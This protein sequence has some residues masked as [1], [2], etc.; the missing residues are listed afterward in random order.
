MDAVS[1]ALRCSVSPR[2]NRL[3]LALIVPEFPPDTIGGGGPVFASL[4]SALVKRG[5]RVRVL[6][7]STYGGPRGNDDDYGFP[8]LRIPQFRHFTSQFRTYMPPLPL[9]LTRIPHFLRGSDVYHLHGY[10][11]AF[12][13]VVF[14]LFVPARRAVFTTHGF[15]HTA[16]R[17]GG[18]LRTSYALYDRAFGSRILRRSARLTA[19]SSLLARE[20]EAYAHR[21]VEVIP[22]G[23]VGIEPDSAIKP[24][25]EIEIEKGPYLLGVGRI[26]ELKGFDYTIRALAALRNDY[27]A[28]RFVVAGA[29]NGRQESLREL[30]RDFGVDDAV[31]FVGPLERG[32]LAHLYRRAASVVVSSKTESFSLVTLEALAAGVPCVASAVG[33]ILDIIEDGTNGFLFPSGDVAALVD[34]LRRVLSSE[35]LRLRFESAGR[36]TVR[37]FSWDKVAAQYE[38]AYRACL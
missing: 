16:P 25:L 26:E 11:T 33:G 32:Q 31:S 1:R 22:N 5:V 28:L 19:V 6:T 2:Q 17:S 23:F 36:G 14:N 13:D 37:R 30:A 27:P 34:R 9:P 7:S 21:N 10:G 24:A 12:I 18:L 8:I 29:D 4:A 3:N 38:S 20:T 35:E 15:P